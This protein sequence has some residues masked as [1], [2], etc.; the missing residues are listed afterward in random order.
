MS[1]TAKTASFNENYRVLK[2]IAEQLRQQTQDDDPDID[3][4]VPKVEAASKAYKICMQRLEAVEKA[5]QE[6]LPETESE[7]AD[8]PNG[9]NS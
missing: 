7:K 5:L 4:L 1:K 2:E 6:H 3:G 8:N 9:T